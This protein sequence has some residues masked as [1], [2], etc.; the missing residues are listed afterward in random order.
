MT[1]KIFFISLIAGLVTSFLVFSQVSAE[2]S[3]AGLIVSPPLK[4]KTVLAGESVSD[5]IKITNPTKGELKIDVMVQDFSARGEEGAQTFIKADENNTGYSLAKWISVENSFNLKAGESKNI[6]YEITAPIGAEPGGHYGVIFFTPTVL[7]PA[8]LTSSSGVTAIPQIG[9]LIL[10]TVPGEISYNGEIAEFTSGKKLYINS[11][12]V[13]DLITRFQNLGN[14]HVKPAGDISIK[15]A[16][17]KEIANLAVNEKAGNVL[18]NSIR[19]FT[20]DWTKKYGFG[21][22]RADIKLISGNGLSYSQELLFWIIPWK[23]TAGTIIIIMVL[24]W[25]AKHIEWKKK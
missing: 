22:Y 4:E 18:P 10:V 9:S 24:I 2:D 16:F 20:N 23:E 21:W 3:G 11:T 14:T 17:G 8:S 19:K 7:N 15:N 1:K 13:I 5:V 25:I 6:N 12:N